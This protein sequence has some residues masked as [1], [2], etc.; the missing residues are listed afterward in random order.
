M[1]RYYLHLRDFKGDLLVDEEGAELPS[2]AAAREELLSQAPAMA[3]F[4]SAEGSSM[5]DKM[6]KG[7]MVRKLETEPMDLIIW[8][9][10]PVW[11]SRHTHPPQ[12]LPL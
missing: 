11:L 10:L 12:I 3:R 6:I 2:L 9:E 5:T 8:Q 1:A 7:R 4:L